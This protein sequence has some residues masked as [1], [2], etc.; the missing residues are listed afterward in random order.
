M[1]NYHITMLHQAMVITLLMHRLMNRW[2]NEYY[3]QYQQENWRRKAFN[4][5]V[6]FILRS[7]LYIVRFHFNSRVYF[8]KCTLYR[9]MKGDTGREGYLISCDTGG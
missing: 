1:Y 2:N 8:K 6:D 3:P 4:L 7:V 5:I 9:A